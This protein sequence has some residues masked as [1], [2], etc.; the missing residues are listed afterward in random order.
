MATVTSMWA[1]GDQLQGAGRKLSAGVYHVGELIPLLA[2]YG[3][4][5]EGGGDD[6]AIMAVVASQ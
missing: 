1:R 5:P 6:G 3:M 2:A 4:S